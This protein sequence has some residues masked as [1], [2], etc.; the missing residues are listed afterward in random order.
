MCNCVDS[1]VSPKFE[2]AVTQLIVKGM[3]PHSGR[4]GFQ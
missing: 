4:P 2:G 3:D 1:I